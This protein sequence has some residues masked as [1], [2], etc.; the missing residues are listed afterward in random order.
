M[1]VK[2]KQQSQYA[3]KGTQKRV[4]TNLREKIFSVRHSMLHTLRNSKVA[5]IRRVAQ[6]YGV[7]PQ[8]TKQ[9]VLRRLFVLH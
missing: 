1:Q 9:E 3:K 8:G 2:K 4:K 5:D 6:K 7:S